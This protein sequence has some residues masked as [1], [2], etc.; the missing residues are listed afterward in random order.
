[1]CLAYCHPTEDS[2]NRLERGFSPEN[3][4]ETGLHQTENTDLVMSPQFEFL[5]SGG[6]CGE[7]S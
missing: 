2:D 7:Q 4:E 5:Q 6:R 3:W 1:M